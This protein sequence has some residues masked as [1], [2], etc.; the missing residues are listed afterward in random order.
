MA[1]TKFQT[2]G[3][4]PGPD[5]TSRVKNKRRMAKLKLHAST[6]KKETV[7]GWT[8]ALHKETD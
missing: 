3:E 7:K 5:D 4:A 6:Y 8:E 1:A 2:N